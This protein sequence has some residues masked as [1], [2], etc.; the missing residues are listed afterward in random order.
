VTPLL[1][2]AARKEVVIGAGYQLTS[3]IRIDAAYQIIKQSDRR[4]RVVDWK[5]G[6]GDL[7][8]G[9][10]KFSANLLGVGA[11]FAF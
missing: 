2:E 5:P 9:V 4:G 6:D 10:Y 11:S 3:G 7:N 1:P 8:T